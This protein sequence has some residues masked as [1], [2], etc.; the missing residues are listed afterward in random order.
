MPAASIMWCSSRCR[1]Q[2]GPASTC[3]QSHTCSAYSS[4][5]ASQTSVQSSR[6]SCSSTSTVTRVCSPPGL[7][8]LPELSAC[9]A[10]RGT[11]SPATRVQQRPT[12]QA[13]RILSVLHGSLVLRPLSCLVWVHCVSTGLVAYHLLSP[14]KAASPWGS[15]AARRAHLTCTHASGSVHNVL[16]CCTMLQTT[17]RHVRC[18][19]HVQWHTA[20]LTSFACQ[21]SACRQIRCPAARSSA[22]AATAACVCSTAPPAIS[23]A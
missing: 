2:P 19:S 1:S 23:A 20:Y 10:T 12:Q 5:T 9:L 6:P 18:R 21:L 3:K 4:A 11:Q 8:T 16:V 22:A 15:V 17:T 14:A 7:S 13:S